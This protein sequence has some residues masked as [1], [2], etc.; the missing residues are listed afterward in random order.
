MGS[1]DYFSSIAIF[2]APAHEPVQVIHERPTRGVGWVLRCAGA[3]ATLF[4][5]LVFLTETGYRFAAQQTLARVARAGALEATLPGA[6]FQTVRDTVARRLYDRLPAASHWQL[7]LQQNE[8]PVRSTLQPSEGDVLSVTIVAS[9]RALLPMW[10]RTLRVWKSESKVE[11]RA[12]QRMPSRR[13]RQ[14]RMGP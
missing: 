8:V 11:A 10:L 12:E 2:P 14:V 1:N 5:S 3:L 4:T 13:I 6:S 9:D 7:S